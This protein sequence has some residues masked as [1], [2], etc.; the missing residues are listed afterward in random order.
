MVDTFF[1]I[2]HGCF[3]NIASQEQIGTH[4]RNNWFS[5]FPEALTANIWYL[6][7]AVALKLVFS[8]LSVGG[9]AT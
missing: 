9:N 7:I 5:L 2:C 3:K 8:G 4:I 1:K 6:H